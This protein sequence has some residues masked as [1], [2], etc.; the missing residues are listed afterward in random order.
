M[1]RIPSKQ[2]TSQQAMV[3]RAPESQVVELQVVKASRTAHVVL[4]TFH[5]LASGGMLCFPAS[6]FMHDVKDITEERT[7]RRSVCCLRHRDGPR[8][9]SPYAMSPRLQ[10]DTAG[11]RFG[12]FCNVYLWLI[13]PGLCPGGHLPGYGQS[14]PPPRTASAR[15]HCVATQLRAMRNL[16]RPFHGTKGDKKEPFANITGKKCPTVIKSRGTCVL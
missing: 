4:R 7:V 15:W 6:L 1:V 12:D 5:G 13:P 11:T 3:S 14:L 2:S 16:I 9:P 10:N 8:P